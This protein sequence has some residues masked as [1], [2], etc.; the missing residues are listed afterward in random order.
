VEAAAI[1][2]FPFATKPA[3]LNIKFRLCDETTNQPIV[4]LTIETFLTAIKEGGLNLES[5]PH[6]RIFCLLFLGY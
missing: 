1:Q 4:I 6:F 5:L 3:S 2:M